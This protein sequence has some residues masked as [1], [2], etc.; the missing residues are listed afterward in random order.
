MPNTFKKM[1]Y[2]V[3]NVL[4][5]FACIGLLG[6]CAEIEE[7]EQLLAA[8]GFSMKYADTPEKL[9]HLKLQVQHTLI[10]YTKEGKNYFVFADTDTCK[11][12]FVGDDKAYQQY[13]ILEVQENIAY[14]QRMTA[15]MNRDWELDG[16]RWGQPWGNGPWNGYGANYY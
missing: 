10:P 11:C 1:R 16:G 5:L 9:E 12:M 4:S 15:E 8:A 2:P 14:Q 3:L 6:A 7:K 13:N